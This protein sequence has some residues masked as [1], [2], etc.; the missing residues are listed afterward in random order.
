VAN[1]LGCLHKRLCR[2]CRKGGSSCSGPRYVLQPRRDAHQVEHGGGENV[3]QT[4][5]G[6]TDVA[7]LSYTT[8]PD[9]LR[10]RALNPGPLGILGCELG[11]LLP[12]PCSLDRLVIGLRPDG[13]LA[14][15]IFGLG[16]R[17]ADRTRPTGC[18][19]KTDAHHGIARDIPAWRP[20]NTGLP[21]GTVGLLRLPVDDK[22]TQIIA[23]V[24]P[25]LVAI[26]PEGWA[27]DINLVDGLSSDEQLGI[28]I[29]TI[30]QVYTGEEMA[31]GQVILNE[32]AHDTIRGGRWRGH[33]T[34]EQVRLI[35]LTGF[36][37][38]HLV[39]DPG[40]TTLGAISGLDIIGEAINAAAGSH[41]C[42]VRQRRGPGGSVYC[43]AQTCRHV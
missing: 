4:R 8:P 34:S 35:I 29:A 16:A 14:R 18:R 7:T 21:L 10:L 5:F 23:L 33:D 37:Q 6:V 39:A 1:S 32:R 42:T 43:S 38:V 3:L 11:S 27:H 19:M 17:L 25:P 9:G 26:R 41:S 22:G 36:G 40:D 2:E 30:E 12:L 28:D 20:S 15:C 31:R 24:C 13:E